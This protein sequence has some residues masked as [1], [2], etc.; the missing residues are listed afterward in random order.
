M[1]GHRRC[2]LAWR[3]R[4]QV[5][6]MS[7][8]RQTFVADKATETGTVSSKSL[9]QPALIIHSPY[10]ERRIGAI[11]AMKARA[12]VLGGNFGVWGGLFSTYDCAVKGYGLTTSFDESHKLTG[13]KHTKEGRSVERN[14]RRLLY[15]W[16]TRRSRRLQSNAQRRH[17]LRHSPRRH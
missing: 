10:G 3:E 2:S 15:R 14:H 9:A 17:H 11:T 1:Q 8:D 13:G 16:I 6:S 4:L 7:D 5:R 12:P